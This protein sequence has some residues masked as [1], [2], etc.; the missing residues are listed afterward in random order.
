MNIENLRRLLLVPVNP[1]SIHINPSSAPIYDVSIDPSIYWTPQSLFY[2]GILFP[3]KINTP[4]PGTWLHHF[5][6]DSGTLSPTQMGIGEEI[7]TE[8]ALRR[9]SEYVERFGHRITLGYSSEK[10]VARSFG[11]GRHT[12]LK[13]DAADFLPSPIP[14]TPAHKVI[15]FLQEYRDERRKFILSIDQLI[16]RL[17]KGE[18]DAVALR[19]MIL[20]STNDFKKALARAKVKYDLKS[21]STF[22]AI[23]SEAENSWQAITNSLKA[24]I[25]LTGYKF[26]LNQEEYERLKGREL[27]YIVHS[28]NTFL[29]TP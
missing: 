28:E 27:A 18:L 22:F 29:P 3:S 6:Y 12:C 17:D 5:D 13:I 11:S 1:A 9:Y 15:T 25:T 26:D 7:P 14:G 16:Q 10:S 23:V 4:I 20:D 24:L 8:T 19:D 2:D 21:L